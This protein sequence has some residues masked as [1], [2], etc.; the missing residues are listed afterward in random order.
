MRR[1]AAYLATILVIIM[2]LTTSAFADNTGKTLKVA[3]F[4]FEGY[5]SYDKDGKPSGYNF[6]YLMEIAKYTGWQYEFVNVTWQQAFELVQTGELDLMGCVFKDEKRERI[7]AYPQMDCGMTSINLFVRRDSKLK[8][9]DF[10]AFN[11]L[12]VGCVMATNNDE[13]LVRFAHTNGFAVNFVNYDTEPE[14]VAAVLAGKVDAGVASSH[15]EKGEVRVV[16]GFGTAPF[17]FITTR[18]NT[19]VVSALNSAINTIKV[20]NNYYERDLAAKYDQVEQMDLIAIINRLPRTLV[21][22]FAMTLLVLV[23]W[24]AVFSLNKGRSLRMSR[25]LLHHD[26]LT[27]THNRKGFENHVQSILSVDRPGIYAILVLDVVAFHRYNEFNGFAAGDALLRSI[28]AFAKQELEK[29]EYSSRYAADNFVFLINA[30]SK[31]LLHEKVKKFDAGLHKFVNNDFLRFHYGVYI[32]KDPNIPVQAMYDLAVFALNS[33]S[34]TDP[35]GNNIAFY[36]EAAYL[37][38]HE[39]SQMLIDA[40]VAFQKKEFVAFYQPKYDAVSEKIRGAEALVRWIRADGSM[41]PPGKFIELFEQN[42][43]ITKLDFYIF[44]ESC[45]LLAEQLRANI[46]IVPVSVNFS[47]AHLFDAGFPDKAAA[48]VEKYALDPGMLEI[49]LT[50]SSFVLDSQILIR[51]ISHLHEHGFKVAID[52]FGSGYSSLGILKDIYADTL[53]IDIKFLEGFEQGGRVGT[54]VTAVLRMAK[55]LEVPVVVEGV[56]TKSQ[57]DFIRSIGGDMIQGYYYSKPVD[58]SGWTQLLTK[59]NFGRILATDKQHFTAADMDILLG[60]SLIVN[61]VLGGLCSGF[62]L[63]EYVDA[64]LCILRVNDGYRKIMGA[65]SESIH[66]YS[67]D[68]MQRFPN[69]DRDEF[70]TKLKQAIRTG[71]PVCARFRRYHDDGHII[72]LEGNIVCLSEDAVAPIIC[73]TFNCVGQG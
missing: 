52:D 22:V 30:A 10:E 43:L 4:P 20:K 73:I 47:R 42:G 63:Y 45:R 15:R 32:I 29:N 61:K 17:Y 25:H 3:W 58:S 67:T 11:D 33:L 18:G 5:Q 54:I 28:I 39:N 12:R 60:G 59:D 57:A 44:E 50:E 53:K 1:I 51:T 69:K 19:E 41:I 16:A 7:Y 36:D 48:I 9:Y 8:A 40:E 65:T 66:S 34:K 35:G 49:E 70:I 14:L 23:M 6:E 62:A 13:E 37:K 38:Q 21:F 31:E 55:W 26:A 64:R 72:Y 56:E 68:V 27:G 24:L 46:P 71:E 2:M